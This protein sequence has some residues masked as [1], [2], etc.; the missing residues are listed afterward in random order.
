MLY[1]RAEE[2]ARIAGLLAD[3]RNGRSG[4]L[5]VRGEAGAGKT[6]LINHAA[7]TDGVRLLRATAVDTESDLP[8]SGLHLLLRGHLDGLDAG[9]DGQT[10]ALRN[11]LGL[12]PPSGRDTADRFLV[13]LAVL[14]LLARLAEDRPLLCLVDD[15][16]WLDHDSA[17][18]LLF[19]GRRLESEG[20]VIIFAAR[21]DDRP[22]PATGLAE[23]RLARLDDALADRLIADRSP[24]LAAA[25]RPAIIRQAQGNPLALVELASTLTPEQQSGESPVLPVGTLP[26]TDRVRRSFRD[27]L[28]LLPESTRRLLGLAAADAGELDL[29][30]AAG[31]SLDLT[32]AA[33]DPA[34]SAGLVRIEDGRVVFR[35]PLLRAVAYREL[36]EAARLSVH[37]ALATEF[38]ERRD[39]VRQAWHLAA[40]AI[41]PDDAAAE[42]LERSARR[43]RS[44]GGYAAESVAY[45]RAARLSSDPAERGRRLAA[46]AFAAADA[47]QRQ[48]V[49]Q[50]AGRA[51][52]QLVDPL[53]R[54][55]LAE[56]EARI[57]AAHGD[58][59]RAH[60]AL[61][62]A[63]AATAESGDQVG[64]VALS[65]D[66]ATTAWLAGDLAAVAEI[67]RHSTEAAA[68]GARGPLWRA[69][70]GL[71]HLAADDAADGLPWL[72]ALIDG[73]RSARRTGGLQQRA[74]LA[75]W[76][77][78]VGDDDAA[79]STAVDLERD[80][81]DRGA[82]GVLPAALTLVTRAQLFR[83]RHREAWAS[84]AEGLRIA[85]DTDQQ[86]AVALLTGTQAYLAAIEGD[87]P[88][89]RELAAR[90]ATARD[91][92]SLGMLAVSEDLLD[93][94][95]GRPEAVVRRAREFD[96]DAPV[97][98]TMMLIHRMPDL[99]EAA[100]QADDHD[101]ARAFDRRIQ[102]WA[103][104]TGQAWS[105]AVAARCAA[106]INPASAD[107]H[108][109]R[110]VRL[111]LA[112]GRPFERARTE[113][114]YGEWLRRARRRAEAAP[115]LESALEHFDRMGARPWADR[116]GSELRAAG[117]RRPATAESPAADLGQLTAQE[118]QVV[119]MAAQ[120]LTNK[121]IGARLFLSHRTVA[122]H[123]HKA[124]PKLGVASRGELAALSLAD[125]GA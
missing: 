100:V 102:A 80:A 67:A 112:G 107:D 95:L 125:Q 13:G 72:G 25:V 45:E 33:V 70:V 122:Y 10:A 53:A 57:A 9:P 77:L 41:G 38:A 96:H 116:A 114:L 19:A 78:L 121:A 16:H 119:R 66:A 15:A 104:L 26:V 94:A 42:A 113:L 56:A 62:Y 1:G 18:A 65:F 88:R 85:R 59:A 31:R 92:G 99:V 2:L 111:H 64:A 28:N 81:R 36:P 79:Y 22:F 124:F 83:G 39:P 11:A 40:A 84:A 90:L 61:A 87:Q 30:L 8:Y 103:P 5:V 46:A 117:R 123:L 35:H 34:E 120:G 110:A 58:A 89:V 48:R 68:E 86:Q 21:D 54:A 50:L 93:L 71:G 69:T 14:T 49:S 91:A 24:D 51:R 29:V 118:L 101:L 47:G 60:V 98:R 109:A 27:R 75:I 17:E 4:A 20:V 37:R 108:F 23:L 106:L 32:L 43:I 55:R 82:I 6:A 3:A 52:D 63:A 76:D 74:Q 115:L 97:A 73:V 105:A 7:A 12:G 44:R